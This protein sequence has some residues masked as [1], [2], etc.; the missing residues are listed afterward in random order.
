MPTQ[1][2]AAADREFT[3]IVRSRESIYAPVLMASEFIS[4]VRR[5]ERLRRLTRGEADDRMAFFR[6]IPIEYQWD[7]AW[8][9]RALDIAREIGAS[10]IYDSI[11]LA[12]A[13]AFDATLYT[14]D[15]AFADSFRSPHPNIRLVA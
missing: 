14:C 7:D 12:C 3:R 11:Y 9:D 8:L 6:R 13:E 5:L 1:F 2:L 10:R 15:E 4:T